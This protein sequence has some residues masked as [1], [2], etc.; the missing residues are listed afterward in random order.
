VLGLLLAWGAAV[1]ARR[2]PTARRTYGLRKGTI[3]A[4]L[5]N[6]ALLLVAVGAIAWEAVRR[7]ATPS[8][9]AGPVM[10][11]RRHRGGDQHRHRPDVHARPEGR[12]ERARRLPAHG[13]RRRRLG[14]GGGRR[15]GHDALTGWLWLD[16]VV[17][18]AI[19]AVIVAGTWGLL[20]D[21]LDLALDAAPRGVDTGA[22][23]AWL[24]RL[25]G[26][27]EVHDLHIWAM[28][29]TETALTAHLIRPRPL[30][31]SRGRRLSARNLR[32]AA[33]PGSASATRP[34]RSSTATPPTA[35]SPRRT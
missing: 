21:S 18:L 16:P 11:G 25:P 4:S 34:C 8:R 1:M 13:R 6:A 28:S 24:E 31:R 15:R 26:V 19:V 12:P 3:L 5:A 22:V 35:A 2:A 23:R 29:T 32:R 30:G 7:F 20:R 9:S 14:R 33:R 27:S 10:I 17:S